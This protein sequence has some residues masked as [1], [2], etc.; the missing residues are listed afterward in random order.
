MSGWNH[1]RSI[2]FYV[3]LATHGERV[4]WLLES[5]MKVIKT[6]TPLM[7][8]FHGPKHLLRS[9]RKPSN[10]FA[11]QPAILAATPSRFIWASLAVP[12]PISSELRTLAPLCC[13]LIRPPAQPSLLLRANSPSPNSC[14]SVLLRLLQRLWLAP[15]PVASAP[16]RRAAD[17]RLQ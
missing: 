1:S 6:S 9:L 17:T 7:P 4:E 11:N 5:S 12:S 14:H 2:I 13:R 16:T 8:T 10:F 15:L 3:C